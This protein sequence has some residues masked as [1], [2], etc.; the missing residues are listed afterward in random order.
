VKSH[1]RD[2]SGV[3]VKHPMKRLDMVW[4]AIVACFFAVRLASAT[5]VMKSVSLPNSEGAIVGA[6]F[7]PDSSRLALLSDLQVADGSAPRHVIKIVEL[8]SV[9]VI[10]HADV[11]SGEP[12]DL[13]TNAHLIAYSPDGR[14]LLLATKGSDVL[15]I[16]D[17]ATLQDLKRVAL[18]PEADSRILLGGQGHRYFRGIMSLASS[19]RAD[20]FGVL[21]HD[22]LQGN[23]VF[24]GSFSSGQIIKNWSLG[25]GRAATQLG[26]I[27]L[28][29]SDDGSR[30][31]VSVLPDGNSLPRG[32]DNLRLYDSGSAEM[33]KSVRTNGLVGQIALLPGENV[34]A[35]RIDTP[36]LFS[37]KVCIEKWSLNTGSL[38]GQLCDQHRNANTALSASVVTGRIAGFAYQLHK[39]VEG[40]VYA[41]SGRVD[42]WDMKSGNLLASSDEI[43]HFVSSVQI[44][45]NGNWV[46]AGQTLMHLSI[47]P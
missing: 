11:L 18:H 34:L 4:L 21:T 42:V 46:L 1:L 31:A 15:S 29:I 32:F 7:S 23:E 19:P 25:R 12:A 13:A 8:G 17:A 26:Q 6:A 43:S 36:G 3:R 38:D 44:S 22:E 27:S 33:V 37:K 28:S 41:A 24:L 5:T 20:V 2:H 16:V 9:K 14:Y 10:A 47:A 39:S 35:S 45:A 30:T 40:Q